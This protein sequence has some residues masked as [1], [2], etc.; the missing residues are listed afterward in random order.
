MVMASAVQPA[1][2]HETRPGFLE[3]R[4]TSTDSYNFLWKKPSGGEI[5]IYV[6]PIVPPGCELSTTGEQALTPGALVVR[7]VLHCASG[8]AGR[9]IA[10]DGLESTVTD[11]LVRVHHADGRLESHLLKP[12][13]PSVTLGASTTAWQR[14]GAYL[15]LGIEHI[16]LG[17]DHLLFVLGLQLI[18]GDRWMLVKTITSFTL[19]HSITLAI[20]TLGY[21]SAPLPPLNAAIALSILFL[22][23]EIVKRWR[24]ETS[25]T[26][27]RP[28]IVAFAFGLLHGFGFASGLTTMGLPQAEI[29]AA[30]L[31]F[32]VG[33][34]IG[35]VGFVGL[36]V[37]LERSFATLE[38]RWPSPV[39][40]LPAYAVGSL[41]AYW[42]IQRTLML[43]GGLR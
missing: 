20:A 43:L 9:T 3:L 21:A 37:L 6:A 4:Q 41:G 25:L 26:I 24:G 11:V 42:T 38:I 16:L 7:G 27:R 14:S 35:Q 15:R 12:M 33:V 29:P 8:I 32:N 5:E 2:G 36:I 31:L 22:G 34:E 23:P 18:V 39:E 1:E 13:N 10:I 17:V 40:A 19:A 30:L 28:W